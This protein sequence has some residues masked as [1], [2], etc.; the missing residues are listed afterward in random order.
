MDVLSGGLNQ[1]NLIVTTALLIGLVVISRKAK[2]LDNPGVLAATAL[3]FVVGGMGHWTWLLI[4]L[5]FLLASHK[6]QSGDLM[7]KEKG[8]CPNRTTDIEV[9]ATSLPTVAFLDWLQYLLSLPKIGT[10]EFG[11]LVLPLLLLHRTHLQ[12]KL[13]A[14]MIM[15]A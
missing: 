6:A 7:K 8:V 13:A 12:V 5:G 15:S 10:T 1:G 3:G 14:L 11:C 4:L 2:M 9:M